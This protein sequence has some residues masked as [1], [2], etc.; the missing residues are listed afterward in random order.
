MGA[1]AI[2]EAFD[3]IKISLRACARVA[4]FAAVNEFQFKGASRSFSMVA[5]S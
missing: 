3:V 2:V 1:L 5:L 4:K